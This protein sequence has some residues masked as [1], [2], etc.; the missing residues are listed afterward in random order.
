MALTTLTL[1]EVGNGS[2]VLACFVGLDKLDKVELAGSS[3]GHGICHTLAGK[4][5]HTSHTSIFISS[6]CQESVRS[7]DGSE[8]DHAQHFMNCSL[9]KKKLVAKRQTCQLKCPS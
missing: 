8:L 4:T 1:M 7:S 6:T 5:V 2:S 3:S 9:Q